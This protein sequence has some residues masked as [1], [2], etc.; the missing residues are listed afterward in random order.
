MMR[1]YQMSADLPL[2]RSKELR[3]VPTLPDTSALPVWAQILVSIL[4][5]LGTL[6]VAFKGYFKKSDEATVT[7]QTTATLAG[8]TV[9][10]NLSIRMLSDAIANLSNDVVSLERC[11]TE[12]NHWLRNKI[13]LDKEVAQRLRELREVLERERLREARERNQGG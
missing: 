7:A 10:D 12:H 6:G 1:A 2:A 4:V 11:M 3:A 8:A 5:C 9:M 13:D